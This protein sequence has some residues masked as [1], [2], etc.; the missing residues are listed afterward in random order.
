MKKIK[1]ELKHYKKIWNNFERGYNKSVK[2]LNKEFINCHK[3]FKNFDAFNIINGCNENI[4]NINNNNI[5]QKSI[6]QNIT[7]EKSKQNKND[8]IDNNKID[9]GGKY[10]KKSNKK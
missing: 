4:N 5:S 9:K 7:K 3:G 6:N 1:D 8:N 10:G 2:Y